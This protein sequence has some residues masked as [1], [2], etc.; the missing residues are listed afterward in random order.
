MQHQSY[1]AIELNIWRGAN[2]KGTAKEW[3]D[4]LL[5]SSTLKDYYLIAVCRQEITM[6]CFFFSLFNSWNSPS[7]ITKDLM[8]PQMR[9]RSH[10]VSVHLRYAVCA[11][12]RHF[13]FSPPNNNYR[14]K[15]GLWCIKL[16]KFRQLPEPAEHRL[17]HF[18]SYRRKSLVL[19]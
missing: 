12:P 1:R 7:K 16:A 10:K 5:I 17:G 19:R 15:K 14:N 13:G 2:S 4:G 11:S 6:N 18:Y 3:S 8:P 9:R